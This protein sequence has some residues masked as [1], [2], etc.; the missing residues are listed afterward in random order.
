MKRTYISLSCTLI[1]GACA[2]SS[3]QG[4][5]TFSWR[6]Y[7]PGNTGIQG[8]YNESIFIDTDGDPWIGGYNPVAE[9]GGVAKFI[10]SQNRWL[11]VS[12]VDYPVIGSANDVGFVRVSDMISDGHGN[13]W[14]GTW[15]GVLKMNLATGPSSIVK[16]GPWNSG[17][18]GGLTRDMTLAPDGTIWVSAASTV[19]AGGGLSRYTPATNSWTNDQSHGG[20]KIAIQPKPGGGYYVFCANDGYSDF[21]KFDTVTQTWTTW[22]NNPPVAGNPA[23]L[24]SK[25][26]VDALGNMWVT[27]WIGDQGEE[28]LDCLRPDGTWISPPLPPQNPSIGVAALRAFGNNQALMVNGYGNLYRYNGTVW[29]DLGAVPHSGFIDDLDI[30][31]AGNIWLCGTGTGGAMKRDVTTGIWQRLRITN[32]SQFDYFNNDLSV[33]PNT[34]AV[35]AAG[36]AASGIGGMVSFDG[37]RWTNF[38]SA[39]GYGLTKPW[40]FNSDQS[41]AVYVRPSN[42]KVV[43]N[44]MN[45]FT[46]EWDGF[47]WAQIPGGPDQVRQYTED[48]LGRLWAIPHYGG[49]GFFDSGSY[50][51]IPMTGWGSGIHRDPSRP[52][53]IWAGS[54]SEI[55]RTDG[56]YLLSKSVADFPVP[57]ANTFS[58]IAVEPN[59]SAWFSTSAVNNP[60]GT[61]LIRYNP[62]TGAT[63]VIRRTSPSW[64]FQA[65]TIQPLRVTPDGKL[66]LMY[67]NEYPSTDYGLY[68]Y[69]GTNVGKF[70]APPNGAWT[71]GG[72]PWGVTDT[73]IKIIPGG[74]ELWMTCPSRGIAVLKVLRPMLTSILVAKPEL[75]GGQQNTLTVKANRAAPA[76]SVVTLSDNSS[77][78]SIPTSV[79][80]PTGSTQVGFTAFSFNPA[81]TETVTVTATCWGSTSSSSFTLHHI[82]AFSYTPESSNIYGGDRFNATINMGTPN[83]ITAVYTF[84]DNSAQIASPIST[85][86]A[87]GAQTRTVTLYTLAVATVENAQISA[88]L[89]NTTATSNVT[90]HP[91][92]DLSTL[93]VS[94]VAVVGGNSATATITMSMV[95]NAGPQTITT[96]D[97]SAFVGSPGSVVVPNGALTQSY[98]VTTTSVQASINVT[99]RAQL[100]GISKTATLNVHP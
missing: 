82:P 38:V 78:V 32:T 71:W 93:A 51:S 76:N 16:Y 42:G 64:P 6:Y 52:G 100:R 67:W 2:L 41:E 62:T 68:W 13:L 44:P 61:A 7:R 87:A 60:A 14:M 77:S 18:P 31:S 43:C 46:H 28:K 95:G 21:E 55:V 99:L 26:S 89:A 70:Q 35:Y 80:I 63:K 91:R 74:Y 65:D 4:L 5:D 25:D 30:D 23:H 84:S 40:N 27:R 48:S 39:Y 59:G 49:L 54:E 81:A 98:T 57:G 29:I 10:Q 72:L 47:A 90:L 22:Q 73:D 11:N 24:I 85:S 88:R 9:E 50:T 92:P 86:I 34:G 37:T 20:G 79:T 83:P 15:R 36:N 56:T 33:D 96:G 53:T 19:W 58:G 8:D 17:L 75:W 69:D 12:N 97:S 45:G 94:P 66:W 3:G 1:L